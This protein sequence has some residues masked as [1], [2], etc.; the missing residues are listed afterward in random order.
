MDLSALQWCVLAVV[1]V[2]SAL[3]TVSFVHG[4]A[5]IVRTVRIGR[6]APQRTAS[7]W[8][9]LKLTLG[10][11]LGHTRFQGRPFIRAAHW[12]VMLS[13]PVLFF[14]LI[15]GFMQALDPYATLPVLGEFAPWS[16]LT[17]A[18]AWLSLAGI[19]LLILVRQAMNRKRPVERN[20]F[21]RS[22]WVM[23]YF[24]EAVIGLVVLCVLLLRALESALVGGDLW[25]FPLTGWL[26][27]LFSGWPSSSLEAAIVVV[28]GVKILVSATWL[29]VVGRQPSAGVAWHRFLALV[30]VYS[31]REL[32]GTPALGGL[33]PLEIPVR[34][35]HS[36]QHVTRA[37][38]PDLLEE[39]E[40]LPD[41]AS[42]GI[43]QI[44]DFT[45]KGLLDFTT[46]TECGRCQ[47]VCPAW[48]TGKP[49]NPKLLITSLRDEAFA[50]APYFDALAT[51]GEDPQAASELAEPRALIGEVVDP[52]A[53]WDCT[54]CGACVQ[55]CPVDIEHLDHVIGLRRHQVLMESAFP[56]EL[57]QMYR[58]LE[59]RGNPF[60]LP[61]RARL[62]WAKGLDFEVPVIGADLEDASSVDYLF[63]VGCAG[64]YE[65][66]AKATTR[67]VAELLHVAGV[68]FAVL[69]DGESCTGDPARRSGNELLFQMLAAT[70][71]EVL[72]EAKVQRI[73]VTCA[74]CFNTL[75]REYSQLGGNFE[76]VHHTE[77]LDAL[78]R[79][80]RL[81]PVPAT[82]PTKI[83]YHDPCYLGRHNQIYAPPRELLAATGV[84]LVEMPRSGENAM[85]CGAGGAHAFME[86]SGGTR[87][88][89][90]R[91]Q[92]ALDTGAQVIAT[93]CPF[94]TVMLGDGVS[95]APDA[96]RPPAQVVDVATVLLG[97]VQREAGGRDQQ[98][99]AD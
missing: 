96:A 97:A 99:S 51:L 12:L 60:G 75:A 94:C 82:E 70:N 77:L 44:T 40:D 31:R 14:T 83:T 32:D 24:V 52:V 87:V 36:G 35:P 84:E 28:A 16:W 20:R 48:N 90:A 46:C 76:V 13:F 50:T 61:E 22:G 66:R 21:F 23:A 57:G 74:H 59:Q 18:I 3:G 47:E 65:D 64:A 33:E 85:C 78:V 93:A 49:L 5:T 43:G 25:H 73:V 45:W 30:N 2:A 92:E 19:I 55:Q 86:E 54:T 1:L 98:A 11:V 15:H 8:R 88:N 27:E 29:Y 62:D 39:L 41:D 38:T 10:E 89:I 56:K 91:S 63:W 95:A 71:L 53:L 7:P 26:G 69:G 72:Q 4:C 6:A 68:S 81:T 9:R 67:A 80:G 37:L 58:K 79:D 42:L 34:D 17:E